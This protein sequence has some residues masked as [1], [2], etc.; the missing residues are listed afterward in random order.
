MIPRTSQY[1][2]LRSSR[3]NGSDPWKIRLVDGADTEVACGQRHTSADGTLWPLTATT[4][5]IS[6]NASVT[7]AM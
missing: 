7:I 6:P 1:H 3:L 4:P 5:M 2:G